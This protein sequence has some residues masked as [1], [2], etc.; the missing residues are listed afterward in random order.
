MAA[1]Q[2]W[3]C[4]AASARRWPCWRL[5]GCRGEGEGGVQ[6]RGE[7]EGAGGGLPTEPQVCKRLHLSTSTTS[8]PATL[9]WGPNP[10]WTPINTSAAWAA[11]MPLNRSVGSASQQTAL[12]RRPSGV[13]C[14]HPLQ[15]RMSSAA[16]SNWRSGLLRRW[17]TTRSS[18]SALP[19]LLLLGSGGPPGRAATAAASAARITACATASLAAGDAACGCPPG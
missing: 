13:V 15:R 14:P 8:Q 3:R 6:G 7:D 10:P 9:G 2:S 19:P 18:T 5:L 11:A 4:P 1:A 12:R 16:L 17:N